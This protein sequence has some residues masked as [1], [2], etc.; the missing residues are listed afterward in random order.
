[1]NIFSFMI[2]MM[3]GKDLNKVDGGPNILGED[4]VRA[5]LKLQFLSGVPSQQSLVHTKS[6]LRKDNW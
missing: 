3:M 1:M 6:V 4:R 2:M 5:L